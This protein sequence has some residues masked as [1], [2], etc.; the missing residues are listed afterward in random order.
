MST[1]IRGLA[2]LFL[3]TS[4]LS[5][6]ASGGKVDICH[7]TGSGSVVL[8]NISASAVAS[9]LAKHGDFYPGTW[10][11]DADGDGYGTDASATVACTAPAGTVDTGGDWND[12]DPSVYPGAPDLCD[13]VD[14]DGDSDVDEDAL[15][16]ASLLARVGSSLY[17]F[18]VGTGA[19]TE[20]SALASSEVDA[21]GINTLTSDLLTGETYGVER[22]SDQLVR[23]D[24]CSGEVDV[25]GAV[26]FSNTCGLTLGPDGDLYGI[27]SGADALLRVDAA[28]GAGTLVGELG[29]NL[30]NCGMAYDCATDTLYGV[31]I[32]TATGGRDTIFTIDVSSGAASEVV[33]LDADVSWAQAGLEVDVAHDLFYVSMA[34][35][36]YAVDALTGDATLLAGAS[37]VDNLSWWTGTCE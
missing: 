5:A 31:H 27:D 35:G 34:S 19:A 7:N 17:T 26:G 1:C 3:F 13:G 21:S 4:S 29:F 36:V 9:H 18:E 24:V 23:V 12:A 30:K 32:D 37:N 11:S 14:N 25:V 2:S 10:Y 16:G 28:T 8:L 22:I 33:T 6:H 20:V 15:E